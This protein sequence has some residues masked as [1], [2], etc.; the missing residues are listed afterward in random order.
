MKA[1]SQY[2]TKGPIEELNNSSSSN[3]LTSGRNL[4]IISIILLILSIIFQ[5]VNTKLQDEL[6]PT[7]S[8]S[9]T[10]TLTQQQEQT[11]ELL[12]KNNILP[13]NFN[14]NNNNKINNNSILIN[15]INIF[16]SFTFTLLFILITICLILF[17]L[18]FCLMFKR[19][20]PSHIQLNKNKLIINEKVINE[21]NDESIFI[22]KEQES[23]DDDDNVKWLNIILNRILQNY[24]YKNASKIKKI[25]LQ[26]IAKEL[27]LPDIIG[28][29]NIKELNFGSKSPYFKNI[30]AKE[31]RN[32][33]QID[34]ALTYDDVQT[35]IL[36]GTEIWLNYPVKYFASF[37]IQF[38]IESIYFDIKIRVIISPDFK[39]LKFS[40]LKQPNFDLIFSNE[41]GHYVPIQNVPILTDIINRQIYLLL[42]EKLVYPKFIEIPL[43]DP[44]ESEEK[45]EKKREEEKQEMIIEGQ[46]IDE[47]RYSSSSSDD[48][49]LQ[50]QD[51][52]LNINTN[53]G[54]DD[55]TSQVLS[56][57]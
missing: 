39:T 5:I 23:K 24:F 34:I 48:E 57:N 26:N 45:K 56:D 14:I 37:P 33:L 1:N 49:E 16:T 13:N 11:I 29:L 2:T 10:T 8:L 21:I 6:N 54:E 44:F 7:T 17:T 35:K 25:I 50:Q 36:L 28:E 27:Q 22:V 52:L 4:F 15:I 32:G 31:D 18:I 55:N 38:G 42:T 46:Q 9:G 19:S 40:F 12:K 30:N 53:V 51:R 20:K 43:P 47:D 41:F 3:N